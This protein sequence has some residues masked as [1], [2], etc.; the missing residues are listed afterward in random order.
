MREVYDMIN[1]Y[2]VTDTDYRDH[3][4]MDFLEEINNTN[5]NTIYKDDDNY[6]IAFEK[7]YKINDG[8]RCSINV[9]PCININLYNK[10]LNMIN[11]E[12]KREDIDLS[13][14]LNKINPVD[15]IILFQE[16]NGLTEQPFSYR[17]EM[18][19]VIE[20]LLE[21]KYGDKARDKA[22]EIVSQVLPEDL[23]DEELINKRDELIDIF[24]DISVF[25]IGA[26]LKLKANPICVLDEVSKVINSRQG[27]IIDGK[28]TKCKT[29]ECVDKWY[30]PNYNKC[31][32]TGNITD[33]ETRD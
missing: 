17:V 29:Q 25:A 28:F 20:E 1:I 3:E 30:T 8:D 5:P 9:L 6:I 23:T 21:I 18:I 14:W 22:I 31:I 13:A 33:D 16:V 10:I 27:E 7:P 11:S 4:I 15:K 26:L 19:N 12:I 2:D 24:A 32:G